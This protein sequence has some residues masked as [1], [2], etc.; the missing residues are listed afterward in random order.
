MSVL[1]IYSDSDIDL[2]DNSSLLAS[3]VRNNDEIIYE[4][5]SSNFKDL[6][7]ILDE[8]KKN[9]IINNYLLRFYL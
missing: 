4:L 8:I 5:T 7:V 2:L 6:K 1:E 3:K 9:N